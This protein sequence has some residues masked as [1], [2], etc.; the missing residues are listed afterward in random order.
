MIISIAYFKI[1]ETAYGSPKA[2]LLSQSVEEMKLKYSFINMKLDE[3]LRTLENYRKNDEICFRPVL[4]MD[5][6]PEPFRKPGYGGVDRYREFNGLP[7]GDVITGTKQKVDEIINLAKVQDESFRIVAEK[8]DEWIR[9]NEHLPKIC[10]VDVKYPRGDGIKFRKEHPVL[11]IARWHLGQDFD[12]PYGTDVHATG[13]GV[14]VTAGLSNGGFGYHVIVD[15]GYGFSTVYGHLSRID[16]TVGMNVKR[17]DQVGLSGNSGT[18]SGPH[19]HYQ[20]NFNGTQKNPLE[21]FADDL[22]PKE[23]REMI[24]T[25]SSKTRF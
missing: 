7:G 22:T 6:I 23:Y 5:S 24:L 9:E 19:L 17:G 11:G 2:K 18:S 8:R 10:P 15:H 14:V 25:L 21:F 12:T 4:N 3:S 13:A 20:I 16:V 1:F